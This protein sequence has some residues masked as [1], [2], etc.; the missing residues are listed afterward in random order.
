MKLKLSSFSFLTCASIFC[1]ASA[2]GQIVTFTTTGLAGAT[3]TVNGTGSGLSS[4]PV[5]TRTGLTAN[6]GSNVYASTANL[7]TQNTADFSNK[8]VGFTVAPATGNVLFAQSLTFAVSGSNT[9]SNQ[10]AVGY[11][12]DGFSTSNSTTGSVTATAVSKS[13]DFTD[14]I[15]NDTV[16]VRIQNFGTTSVNNG[17]AAAG[18]SF[19]LT[20]PSVA[21][22]GSVV[23]A[24]SGAIA[25]AANTEIRNSGEMSLGGAVTGSFGITKTGAG[26]LTLSG[27]NGYSGTTTVSAGTLLVNGDSSTATGAVSVASGATLGGNGTIGG[28]TSISG[29]HAPG[30]AATT[31]GTQ[32]FS[33]SVE[34]S[35]G[36]IFSWDLDAVSTDPGAAT[37][38][39][40]PYDKVV[41][42]GTI[43]GATSV[44]NV[45]LGSGKAFTDAFWNTNKSWNDIFTGSSAPDLASIFTTIGGTGVSAGV[46][47]GQ[48]SFAFT[49][50]TLSWTAFTPVPEPSSAL[51]GL[52]LGAGLLRRRRSQTA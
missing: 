37:L 23:T 39:A 19:R 48:G 35:S 2:Y 52:L 21:L 33:S 4:T 12:T 32:N 46:V 29:T 30:S 8:Y 42:S 34:Y 40:G 36:S 1:G 14:L 7:V 15:T 26:A 20:A 28:A 11:S 13:Y 51:A 5:L 24:A 9:T 17:V 3:A 50:N 38:N 27:T 44:F 10:Y 31:V 47:D 16:S 25:L 49:G 45:V 18:G 43:T 6:S 41:A 22:T